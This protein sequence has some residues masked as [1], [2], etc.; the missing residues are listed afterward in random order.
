MKVS[1]IIIE[2]E[3]DDFMAQLKQADTDTEKD[4]QGVRSD[5]SEMEQ[6]IRSVGQFNTMLNVIKDKVTRKKQK[7]R[8]GELDDPDE[9]DTEV[10]QGIQDKMVR[11]G[12]LNDNYGLTETT[13]EYLKYVASKTIADPTRKY[14]PDRYK[15]STR[16][17]YRPADQMGNFPPKVRAD[18]DRMD[19]KQTTMG[20]EDGKEMSPNRGEARAGFVAKVRKLIPMVER[21]LRDRDR[22]R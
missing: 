2:G 21:R 4:R 14:G 22:P 7:S 11:M 15:Q 9:L 1:D 16:D 19:N 13:L 20:R 12:L 3:L 17:K 8:G 6:A 10:D 5:F 18:L